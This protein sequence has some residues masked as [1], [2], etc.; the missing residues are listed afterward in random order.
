M[1][2]QHTTK[3]SRKMRSVLRSWIRRYSLFLWSEEEWQHC[4]KTN[5]DAFSSCELSHEETDLNQYVMLN[6]S[7]IHRGCYQKSHE[8]TNLFLGTGQIATGTR[9]CESFQ[10][11]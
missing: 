1:W 7:D 11:A 9:T 4:S 2:K 5:T 8:P 10:G 6:N 3:Y